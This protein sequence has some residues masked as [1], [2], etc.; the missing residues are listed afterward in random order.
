METDTFPTLADTTRMVI[1]TVYGNAPSGKDV[2][3][4]EVQGA[5]HSWHAKDLPTSEII[6]KFF[7]ATM[8]ED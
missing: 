5:K 7:E 6:W 4:Y 3:V 2:V 8:K 1:R